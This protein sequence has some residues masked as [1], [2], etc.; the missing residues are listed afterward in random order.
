MHNSGQRENVTRWTE[1]TSRLTQV[2]VCVYICSYI[3]IF[4]VCKLTVTHEDSVKLGCGTR[5]TD[6]AKDMHSSTELFTAI[7]TV[8]IIA[9]TPQDMTSMQEQIRL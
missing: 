2:S 5:H 8:K 3:T 4:H 6:S 9:N 1:I 7:I